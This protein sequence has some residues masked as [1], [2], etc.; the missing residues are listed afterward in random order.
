[1]IFQ[2]NGTTSF[3]ESNSQNF[4]SSIEYNYNVYKFRIRDDNER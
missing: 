2:N 4:L 1:M 3:I